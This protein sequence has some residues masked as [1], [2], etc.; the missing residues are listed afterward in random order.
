MFH[1]F[2]AIENMLALLW[3]HVVELRKAIPHTLLDLRREITKTR[4]PFERALLI[5]RRQV[6]VMTHPLRQVFPMR[7]SWCR[8]TLRI[9]ALLYGAILACNSGRIRNCVRG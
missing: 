1:C 3:G 4:L 9:H 8:A 6:A 2:G 7:Q 5:R